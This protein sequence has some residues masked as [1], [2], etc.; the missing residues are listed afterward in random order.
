LESRRGRNGRAKK[1]DGA[2]SGDDDDEDNVGGGK[3][4]FSLLLRM[5]AVGLQGGKC[6]GRR[7]KAR[8]HARLAHRNE[9]RRL[10]ERE[11]ERRA[12]AWAPRKSTKK[13]AL[14]RGGQTAGR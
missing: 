4:A 13:E 12:L 2:A 6:A 11:R 10:S 3:Q 14:A 1:Q 7:R 9:R 8:A 5:L